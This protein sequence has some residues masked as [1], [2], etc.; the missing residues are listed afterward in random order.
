MQPAYLAI[1]RA[2]DAGITVVASAGNYYNHYNSPGFG[3]YAA[4]ESTVGAMATGSNGVTDT[5]SL[6]NQSQRRVDGLGAPGNGIS[7]YKL[8]GTVNRVAGTSFASPFIAGAVSLLQDVSQQYLNRYLTSEEMRTVLEET[9]DSLNNA[10]GYK[11]ID[12]YQAAERIYELQNPSP[13]KEVSFVSINPW[14]TNISQVRGSVTHD[15]DLLSL[16]GVKGVAVAMDNVVNENTVLS[17]D[18]RSTSNTGI[19]GIG[20][21]NDS[22]FRR[23]GIGDQFISLNGINNSK[24]G[25]ID[26]YIY[27]GS[28]TW[29]RFEVEIGKIFNGDFNQITFFSERGKSEFQNVE[30]VN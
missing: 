12:V 16:T 1:Q 18:Y 13:V 3:F 4:I 28:N 21:D 26:D 11:E 2:E 15:K 25:L 7:T 19:N 27:T 29:Q 9:A 8:N 24:G 22:I 5:E 30:I 6:W 23:Y 17:F 20:F 14:A 10:Q